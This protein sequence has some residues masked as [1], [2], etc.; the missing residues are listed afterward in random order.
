MQR[1][2]AMYAYKYPEL[3]IMLLFHSRY[4]PFHD[5]KD[6]HIHVQYHVRK[7]IFILFLYT[8]ITWLNAN[9]CVVLSI[10]ALNFQE[11]LLELASSRS[12][13]RATE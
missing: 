6:L 7:T 5:S 4:I 9:L 11:G 3:S 2:L 8:S 13:A 10:S 1:N 12:R